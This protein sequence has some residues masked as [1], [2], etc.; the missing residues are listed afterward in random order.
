MPPVPRERQRVSTPLDA[1]GSLGW[2]H[3]FGHLRQEYAAREAS[4]KV[5]RCPTG[6]VFT[7]E[8]PKSLDAQRL[9][10]L[11]EA[12][13]RK[14]LTMLRDRNEGRREVASRERG[15]RSVEQREL[16]RV[17]FA[18]TRARLRRRFLLGRL[19][20]TRK[21]PGS[22]S[23]ADGTSSADEAGRDGATGGG[24]LAGSVLSWIRCV[25]SE[26]SSSERVLRSAKEMVVSV[27]RAAAMTQTRLRRQTGALVPCVLAISAAALRARER[28]RSR[29]ASDS[30]TRVLSLESRCSML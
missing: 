23:S 29:V 1:V 25:G 13:V 3:G 20:R 16:E 9:A 24:G 10:F 2:I 26:T 27:T 22:S 6:F 12:S 19:V 8:P 17:G 18:R 11:D 30:A 28:M 4:A 14:S 15:A 5:R 21:D 7:A